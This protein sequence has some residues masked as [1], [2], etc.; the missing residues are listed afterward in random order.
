MSDQKLTYADV[1]PYEK[2]F[3]MAP[4]FVLG[5]MIKKNTNLVEKFK[6]QV[7]KFMSNLN[8][9]QKAQLELVFNSDVEDLQ[10][11]M[12]DAYKKT[13]K[14]Q[15]KLLADPKNKNFIKKNINELK[16]IV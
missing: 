11:V 12:K 16:K 13:K 3:T 7:V 10:L 6:P 4:S 14:K 5:V 8:D 9:K 15:Y 1:K 2:L